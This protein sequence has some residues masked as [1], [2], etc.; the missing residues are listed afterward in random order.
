MRHLL[1]IVGPYL[2]FLSAIVLVSASLAALMGAWRE[3]TAD[4]RTLA[5][6]VDAGLTAAGKHGQLAEHVI[7]TSAPKLSRALNVGEPLNLWRLAS[8]PDKFWLT[9]ISKVAARYGAVVI[10]PEHVALLRG[11]ANLDITPKKMARMGLMPS[12]RKLA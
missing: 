10:W 1:L 12:A 2:M 11:A 3:H 4:S 6:D 8:L 5:A 9:F 7:G